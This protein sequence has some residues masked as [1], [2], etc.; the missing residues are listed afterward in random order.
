MEKTLSLYNELND[1]GVRFYHWDLG[2]D[3]TV[4]GSAPKTDG[5]SGHTKIFTAR[6]EF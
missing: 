1:N 2:E 5:S 4:D 3:L 6:M